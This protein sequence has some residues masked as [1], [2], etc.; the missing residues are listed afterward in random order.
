MSSADFWTR[1]RVRTTFEDSAAIPDAPFG[2]E[3]LPHLPMLAE[4][5]PRHLT[6]DSAG[7]LFNCLVLDLPGPSQLRWRHLEKYKKGNFP[8]NSPKLRVR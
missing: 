8:V 7:R 5:I 1:Y 6:R 3:V 2:Y 4:R